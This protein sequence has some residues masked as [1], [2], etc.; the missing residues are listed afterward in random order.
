EVWYNGVDNDCSGGAAWKDYDQ[1]GDDEECDGS[2]EF[3][4][5]CPNHV[6]TDCDDSAIDRATI[7]G[8]S[9]ATDLINKNEASEV[10]YDNVDQDCNKKNDFDADK[11]D[12]VKEGYDDYVGGSAPEI[13]DCND[14]EGTINPDED[15]IFYDGIDQNCDLDDDNDKDD[16]GSNCVPKANGTGCKAIQPEGS[17]C[18]DDNGAIHPNATEVCFND[19][20]DD[21]DGLAAPDCHWGSTP[22]PVSSMTGIMMIKLAPSEVADGWD[23]RRQLAIA[24]ITGNG[25]NE[26]IIGDALGTYVFE[27]PINSQVALQKSDAIAELDSSNTF[28]VGGDH[29]GN[30]FGDL[31]YAA[32]N[33]VVA[34]EGPIVDSNLSVYATHDVNEARDI[35]FLPDADGDGD[36]EVAIYDYLTILDRPVYVHDD[37]AAATDLQDAYTT[38]HPDYST[39][40]QGQF[41]AGGNGFAPDR[42]RLVIGHVG[43]GGYVLKPLLGD[44]RGTNKYLPID[45][46][47]EFD[48]DGFVGAGQAVGRPTIIGDVMVDPNG[49][50]SDGDGSSDFVLS[51]PTWDN[52][53]GTF[54]IV[55]SVEGDD[56]TAE[57]TFWPTVADLAYTMCGWVVASGDING[58]GH[59]DL[60]VSRGDQGKGSV[61]LWW[62]PIS[63]GNYN[64]TGETIFTGDA[65]DQ[66]G[67]YLAVG[68]VTGDGVDDLV[69]A[70]PGVNPVKTYIIAGVGL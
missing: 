3:N 7:H 34:L 12:Y 44:N 58:D 5:D 27:G 66:L 43:G 70:A 61:R 14:D 52:S 20:D 16:D 4:P 63:A 30:G 69:I 32:G 39:N 50:G 29:T 33:Q 62:G 28:A 25:Y 65:G 68:D 11:D 41:L 59:E 26:V 6:G 31:V 19:I 54:A 45:N 57:A 53:R 10:F 55:S 21:C 2:S 64:C 49:D 47:N 8:T 48:L 22:T 35:V 38:F 13:G 17:D 1:D 42:F 37:L 51:M 67:S 40:P 36:D 15:E 24:D 9:I 46:N 18:D 23:V 60:V 56:A